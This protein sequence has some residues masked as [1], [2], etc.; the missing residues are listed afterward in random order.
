MLLL[1]GATARIGDP[2]GKNSDREELGDEAVAAN[3][4]A[5]RWDEIF[6][7]LSR[8]IFLTRENLERVIRHHNNHFWSS[9]RGVPPDIEIVD[10]SDW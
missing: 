4:G 7:P 3:T 9:D 1:G 8:L 6:L 5:I 2:S 10:N